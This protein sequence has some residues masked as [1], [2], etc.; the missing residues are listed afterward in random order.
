MTHDPT[1][2]KPSYVGWY[3]NL[4]LTKQIMCVCVL[5]LCV[6]EV[7]FYIDLPVQYQNDS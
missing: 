3:Q 7:D 6:G 2:T 1:V 5:N 4:G